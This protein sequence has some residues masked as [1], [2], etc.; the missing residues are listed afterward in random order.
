MFRKFLK[1]RSTSALPGCRP[2]VISA[3]LA[4]LSARSDPLTPA[5]PEQL[6]HSSL[7]SRRLSMA[8]C[9]SEQPS[10]DCTFCSRFIESVR[11]MACVICASRWEASHF[12]ACVTSSPS[13]V[14][15]EV[16]TAIHERQIL[17]PGTEAQP[18]QIVSL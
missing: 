15:L 18:L 13:I 9:Q 4:S 6:M 5:C 8:V 3:V 16:V 11:I 1:P 10:Q 2:D 12:I 7:C 17:S 14:G